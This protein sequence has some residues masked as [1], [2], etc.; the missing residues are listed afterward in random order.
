MT[1]PYVL[2][3][4]AAADLRGIIRY[5]IRQLGEEQSLVYA[6]QLNAAA[7][8][9]AQGTGTFKNWMKFCPIYV[10]GTR[11]SIFCSACHGQSSQH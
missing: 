5:T 2:T 1:R 11:A 7:R 10:C 3:Q 6:A 8:E 9:V 4:G